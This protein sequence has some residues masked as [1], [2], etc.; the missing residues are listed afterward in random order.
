V[1]H[2]QLHLRILLEDLRVALAEHL[3]YPRI[4]YVSGT[5]PCGMSGTKIIDRKV[6]NSARRRVF[7]Q[8]VLSADWCPLGLRSL[9][10]RNGPS[11]EIAISLLKA[12]MAIEVTGTSATPFGVF[13][14]GIQTTGLFRSTCSFLMGVSSL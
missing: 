14:S 2:L 7:C 6:G 5:Q 4:G 13:E 10:N 1:P 8:T 11:S 3:S 12:S 9:G